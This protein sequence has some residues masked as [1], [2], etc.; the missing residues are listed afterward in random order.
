ME[1]RYSQGDT[2]KTVRVIERG[3]TYEL[4]ID[5]RRYTV[6]AHQV[7]SHT[8]GLLINGEYHRAHHAAQ[9]NDRWVALGESSVHA[10]RLTQRRKR[11]TQTTGAGSLAAT[12]PGQITQ[13]L[14]QAGDAVE[15]GQLMLVME[16]MKMEL[17]VVAPADGTVGKVLVA[18]GDQVERGQVLAEMAS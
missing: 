7:D 15:A 1:F 18:A 12:M 11:R 3:A 16:A 5:D 17:R 2:T 8:L 4:W 10:T 6:S 14:V 9:G 13:V